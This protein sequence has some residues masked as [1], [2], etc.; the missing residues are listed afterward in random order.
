MAIGR[1]KKEPFFGAQYI[2]VSSTVTDER[3]HFM[4]RG[5]LKTRIQV[6]LGWVRPRLVDDWTTWKSRIMLRGMK[7]L[8]MLFDQKLR[9]LKDEWSHVAIE[10]WMTVVGC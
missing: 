5:D 3:P 6:Q 4:K 2:K 7:G 9:D 1:G 8:N 10:G